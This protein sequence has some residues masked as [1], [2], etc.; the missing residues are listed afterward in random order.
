MRPDAY[1]SSLA[2]KRRRLGWVLAADTLATGM[3]GMDVLLWALPSTANV[4]PP[5]FSGGL[6]AGALGLVGLAILAH[7]RLDRERK[8]HLAKIF[9]Q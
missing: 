5:A 3:F 1:L 7:R 4:L 6:C 2:S 8:N 9:R